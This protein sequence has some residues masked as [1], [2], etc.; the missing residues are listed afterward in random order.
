VGGIEGLAAFGGA[1]LRCVQLQLLEG[2]VDGVEVDGVKGWD[3]SANLLQPSLR[4]DDE[5]Q[6]PETQERAQ[7]PGSGVASHPRPAEIDE[8]RRRPLPSV[9]TVSVLDC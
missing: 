1:G 9:P 8:T 4:D 2:L 5:V 7:G 6:A 3:G